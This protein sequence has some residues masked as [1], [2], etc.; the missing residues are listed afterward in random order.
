[1]PKC[2]MKGVRA[3][4]WRLMAAAGDCNKEI[5]AP[6]A[7]ATKNGK[8]CANFTAPLAEDGSMKLRGISK[9]LLTKTSICD[10]IGATILFLGVHYEHQFYG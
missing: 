10:R 8:F 7:A 5:Q 9:V 2:W 4:A 1:M 6:L 3:S